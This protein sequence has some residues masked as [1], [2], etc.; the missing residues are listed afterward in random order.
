MKMGRHYVGLYPSDNVLFLE[1][2]PTSLDNTFLR[3]S[4]QWIAEEQ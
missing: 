3:K 2:E 1:S 4:L